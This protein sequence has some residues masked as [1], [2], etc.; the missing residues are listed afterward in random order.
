M[1]AMFAG[2]LAM[3]GR[4]REAAEFLMV[5]ERH[6]HDFILKMLGPDLERGFAELHR[7][8]G[9]R[10]SRRDEVLAWLGPER[11][12]PLPRKAQARKRF[13]IPRRTLDNWLKEDKPA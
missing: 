3:A 10:P 6:R 5:A 9:G 11:P 2:F 13:K 12:V 4:A 7:N 1:S 8:R